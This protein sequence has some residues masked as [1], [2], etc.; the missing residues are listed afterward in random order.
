MRTSVS[1]LAHVTQI[2]ISPMRWR[3]MQCRFPNVL[4]F[5]VFPVCGGQV[6]MYR[7]H[8]I[9]ALP[10]VKI[11]MAY[12]AFFSHSMTEPARSSSRI[13]DAL[14]SGNIGMLRRLNASNTCTLSASSSCRVVSCHVVSCRVVPCRTNMRD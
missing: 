4:G 14:T 6:K 7:H 3:P 13:M 10:T 12:S 5:H 11:K 1:K 8:G 9:N 2:S